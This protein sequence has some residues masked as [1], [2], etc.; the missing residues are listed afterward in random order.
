VHELRPRDR[1]GR[2]A[3]LTRH[4]RFHRE[5]RRSLERDPGVSAEERSFKLGY[6][7]WIINW[8]R[9]R[10]LDLEGH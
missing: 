4:L 6:H 9:Q 8:L 5:R 3:S 2:I 10:L 7:D 1:Q